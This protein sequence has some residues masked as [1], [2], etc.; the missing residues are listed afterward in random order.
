[1][2]D[3]LRAELA[4]AAEPEYQSFQQ[5][6]CPGVENLMGVRL[7]LLRKRA[8]ALAKGNWR[9]EFACPDETFE[10]LLLRGMVI[11]LLAGR[12]E[13]EEY[14][15]LIR[16]YIPFLCDWCSCDTFCSSLKTDKLYKEDYFSLALAC[17]E[18]PE[19]FICRFGVVLLRHWAAPDTLDAVLAALHTA[20][21]PAFYARMARA[22][23]YADCAAV[24]FEP[25]LRAMEAASL[26][27][28]TW[29]K[30]LQK[31]RESRRITPEQ[32]ELCKQWKRH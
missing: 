18:R 12:V 24:A 9:V 6:L 3:T 28:F 17:A 15:A 25:T 4:A 20:R 30:A 27:D 13:K 8:S 26:D 11:G 7:P 21:C 1:M 19:E 16:A 22:W 32:K 31:M 14:F 10:E 5:K 23:C 29:N 2:T